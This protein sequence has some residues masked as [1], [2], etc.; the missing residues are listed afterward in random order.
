M[1]ASVAPSGAV[2]PEESKDVVE[3]IF[4]VNAHLKQKYKK[5]TKIPKRVIIEPL[6]HSKDHWKSGKSN[7]A[8]RQS[9]LFILHKSLIFYG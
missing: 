6:D 9:K 1:M 7:T 4:I 8:T 3:Q 2:A 5:K